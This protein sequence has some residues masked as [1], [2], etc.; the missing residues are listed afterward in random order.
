MRGAGG[1]SGGPVFRLDSQGRVASLAGLMVSGTIPVTS[2]YTGIL[3]L[4]NWRVQAFIKENVAY[5]EPPKLAISGSEQ[6]VVVSWTNSPGLV[7]QTST[8][9]NGS[10][11]DSNVAIS[12]TNELATA[13]FGASELENSGVFRLIRRH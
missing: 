6:G 3:D 4:S 8:A 2:S 1:D 12:T 7:L 5:P 10:W 13:R 9:P 11:T